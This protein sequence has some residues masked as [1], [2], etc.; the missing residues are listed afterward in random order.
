LRAGDTIGNAG[1]RLSTLVIAEAGVN[2]NGDSVVAKR[3]VDAAVMAGADLVKFQTFTAAGL[4]TR[5]AGKAEYQ[6]RGDD[7][8]E[9]QL[10][11]LRRLELS[12]AMH[13][14]LIAHCRMRN[15]GF[16][17]TAFDLDSIDMLVELG[18]QRFKV[19]SGELTNLPYLRHIGRLR[20]P[21]IVSTGMATLAEVAA[22][23]A[24]LE[25]AGTERAQIVALHCTTEY[26]T[27]MRD[28]N[29][30]AML[31]MREALGVHIGYSDHTRGIEVA[32]AAVALG[33]CV[34][35][36]HLTLDRHMPGPDH[37]SSLEPAELQAMV[38]A[39][40]N[41]ECALGD[42]IK[43][44]SECER[45]NRLIVRK[46]IVAAQPIAQGERFTKDNLTVKRPG[47]GL[48]PMRLDEVLGR[49]AGRSFAVDELI[50]L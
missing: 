34:I 29:L 26:P 4:A 40:R 5:S 15:I 16:L 9:S 2:H 48:S 6:R 8:A 23:I 20:R 19:P 32:V 25:E 27:P 21:L 14:E 33:A 17:S 49:V 42:G 18:L 12:R 36:K 46:S 7:D 50:E 28:V 22:A 44:P 43:Q 31:T 30:R 41:I 35:E 3:L 47:T 45:D 11:M 24:V 1:R 10:E 39:I 38:T 13:E 37:Q